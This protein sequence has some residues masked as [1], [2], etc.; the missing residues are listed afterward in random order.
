MQAK[1]GVHKKNLSIYHENDSF[2]QTSR[3]KRKQIPKVDHHENFP[4]KVQNCFFNT[5]T[6]SHMHMNIYIY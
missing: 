6:H 1:Y 2:A 3:C 5:D 4:G